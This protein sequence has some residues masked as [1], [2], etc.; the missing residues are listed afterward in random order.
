MHAWKLAA[1]KLSSQILTNAETLHYGDVIS[2]SI[3]TDHEMGFLTVNGILDQKC[4]LSQCKVGEYP[5]K[6]RECLFRVQIPFLDTARKSL[7]RLFDDEI[8]VERGE[9]TA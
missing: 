6:F 3:E 8:D 9:M 4:Q 5:P 7:K 1:S 2:L